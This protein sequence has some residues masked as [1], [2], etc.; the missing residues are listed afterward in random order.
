MKK[1][2]FEYLNMNIWKIIFVID[3]IGLKKL[4]IFNF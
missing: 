2:G 1:M 4:K 3:I